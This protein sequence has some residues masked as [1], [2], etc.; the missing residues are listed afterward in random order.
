MDALSVNTVMLIIKELGLIGL[1][2]V[3]WWMDGR[4]FE[5]LMEEHRAA[6][7]SILASYKRDLDSVVRMYE[8]NVT[9]VQNYQKLANELS[10]VIH[11]NTQIQTKLVDHIEHNQF[12]P[13][14]R[15]PARVG[16]GG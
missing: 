14:A 12:C 9:L 16:A 11:L 4:R 6:V 8:S 10:T 15:Q 13:L 7:D 5:R 1:F 3:L 2:V